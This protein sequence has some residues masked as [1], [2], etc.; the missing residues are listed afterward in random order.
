MESSKL[1]RRS[2]LALAIAGTAFGGSAVLAGDYSHDDDHEVEITLLHSGDFH[3]DYH[4]HTNGRGDASGRM[5]GGIARAVTKLNELRKDEDNVIHVHTGDTIHGSGEA[6]IT[7]GMALVKLVDQLGIDVSTPGNWEFAYTPYRYMQFF[8]VHDKSGNNMD[9]QA[10]PAG[11]K[12][13]VKYTADE[14]GDIKS[15]G[16]DFRAVKYVAGYEDDGTPI[17]KTGYNRWGMVASN[18]YQNG[19]WPLDAGVVSRGDGAADKG[20]GW[21]LTPPYRSLSVPVVNVFLMHSITYP[22]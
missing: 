11:A 3:G 17:M 10:I 12:K 5:E 16:T 1:F 18:V 21:H 15:F 20:T 9:I 7:K 13:A 4:P 6:S 14:Q 2:L 22:P 19:S 8:G